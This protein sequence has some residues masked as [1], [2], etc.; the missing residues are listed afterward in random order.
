[1][2]DLVTRGINSIHEN[3]TF[4]LVKSLQIEHN[5]KHLLFK[6][7]ADKLFEMMDFNF[8]ACD[9]QTKIKISNYC[10]NY[11]DTMNREGHFTK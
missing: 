4:D 6:V 5:E 1:M 8:D 7:V 2:N 10:F 3:L 9:E 11:I